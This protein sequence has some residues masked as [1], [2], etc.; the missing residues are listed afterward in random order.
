VSQRTRSFAADVRELQRANPGKVCRNC[1][2]PLSGRRRAYCGEDC[3]TAWLVPR[4]W[5]VA[6]AAV[7]ARDQGVCASCGR[8][9]KEILKKFLSFRARM[10][11]KE[12][13]I[14][15][16]ANAERRALIDALNA[17]GFHLGLW[18][19]MPEKGDLYQID[20]IKP[21]A[22]GGGGCGLENLQTLCTSCHKAKT[23]K[24]RRP[25]LPLPIEER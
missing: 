9:A 12:R 1:S 18:V 14:A 21:V 6:V 11:S 8:D 23:A 16:A 19:R 13:A 20:H 10:A 2:A 24:Q 25:Q 15:E 22:E 7:N 3:K 17:E 4:V 5:S